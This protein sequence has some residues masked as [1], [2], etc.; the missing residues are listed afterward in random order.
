MI[1]S[2]TIGLEVTY[3]KQ[4]VPPGSVQQSDRSKK[5]EVASTG[6]KGMAARVNPTIV[7]KDCHPKDLSEQPNP[8]ALLTK[9][10]M[11]YHEANWML[12]HPIRVKMMINNMALVTW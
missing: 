7:D 5:K 3:Q 2:G 12:W 8:A 9:S 11:N 10:E 6:S 4:H 1:L